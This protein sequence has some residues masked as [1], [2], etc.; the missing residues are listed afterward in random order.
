[1]AERDTPNE[2]DKVSLKELAEAAEP[3]NLD[4]EEP[5][6]MTLEEL[7]NNKDGGGGLSV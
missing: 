1:M 7:S 4:L 3:F 5:F 2:Q 6:K